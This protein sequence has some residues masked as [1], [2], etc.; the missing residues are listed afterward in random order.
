VLGG[1]AAVEATEEARGGQGARCRIAEGGGRGGSA[2]DTDMQAAEDH[3]SV[4]LGGGA[5]SREEYAALVCRVR[6]GR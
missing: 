6:E 4:E 5:E 3:R 1:G 2:G